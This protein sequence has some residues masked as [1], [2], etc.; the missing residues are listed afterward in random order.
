MAGPSSKQRGGNQ[1]VSDMAGSPV[2]KVST[3]NRGTRYLVLGRTPEGIEVLRPHG[4][5]SNFTWLE[6]RTALSKVK[7]IKKKTSA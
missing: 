7:K 1:R 5:P 6:L 3:Q 2:R 4:N